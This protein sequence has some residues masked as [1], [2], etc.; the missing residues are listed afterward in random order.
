[1]PF[2]TAVRPLTVDDATLA[3]HLEHADAAALLMTVAHLT[4]DLSLLDSWSDPQGW[5]SL[6]R[7]QTEEQTRAARA[8]A[9]RVLARHRD[10]G[11]V[12]PPPPDPETLRRITTWAMGRD[13]AGLLPLLTE[14]IVPPDADPR[15]PRWTADELAPGPGMRVAIVGAGMSG[16]LAAHRLAQAGV[17]F[18][19]YEKNDDVG[20]TWYENRYPGCRVD[21][22]SHL[23]SYSFATRTDWPDHFC[24]QPELQRYF[25]EFAK[26]HGLYEHI[27]FGTEVRSAHWDEESAGWALTLRTSDGGTETTAA[28]VLVSAVGQLN[29]PSLPDLPGRET[30][31]G[32]AFHSAR[33]DH[34]VDLR[35]KRVAVIG[36]GASA[37]Q[38]IPELA[39][40]A[41]ELVV[42]QRTPPWLR[43][44]PHYHAPVTESGRWLLEHVP[45]YAAWYRFW[46]F[47]PGLHGVLENW[48]V[49]PDYP[50]TERAVSEGN[51][52]VRAVLARHIE[53]QV[54][55]TPELLP[56]VLPR[57]P[58][59]AKRVLRDDG[60]WIRTLKRDDVRLVDE[61]IERI[62]PTGVVTADGTEHTVDV[63]VYGTGFE[64]SR[65]LAP[66]RVT[67]RGGL[68]LH[69]AWGG[70]ARAY[71]GLT[72]PGFPNLF[73]LYGPNT[74]LSGQGGSIFY[75]SECGVS[76]V[77][78]ALR[79]LLTEGHRSLDLREDVFR[80]FNE[81]L[82]EANRA[83]AWGWS[84][85]SNWVM[86]RAAGRTAQNWPFTAQEYWEQTR[87][88][89]PE[90]YELS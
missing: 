87:R 66:M 31:A 61:R 54:A 63:I 80:E 68:D 74:N 8:L 90:E 20:G 85:V 71:L 22:P 4:G 52:R 32:P 27:R 24:T 58:V 44:T 18:V 50:P 53:E 39:G 14:E 33:W 10:G 41:S 45:Y 59:G 29:R 47:A 12:P 9:L 57:Y 72:V 34:S 46:L 82:D 25:R 35:G 73:C 86:D 30:F 70:S 56:K 16:L 88:V 76:Y 51:E 79:L 42:L 55:D 75:F 77:L 17:P 83:R 40:T 23:Y 19:V 60:S 1:M 89:R 81:R 26:E 78:D 7:A 65:F 5:L 37:F 48:I 67:G 43:P 3:A 28:E 21:V 38:F 2:H 49:D 6:P 69:E 11:S 15:A 64:A 62:T 84:S 13:T 36:T